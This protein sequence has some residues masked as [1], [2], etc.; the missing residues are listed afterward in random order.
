MKNKTMDLFESSDPHTG[1][2]GDPWQREPWNPG[3]ARVWP[4]DL[5][6]GD[7]V[8][9]EE[10]ERNYSGLTGKSKYYRCVVKEHSTVSGKMKTINSEPDDEFP[11]VPP[12]QLG[13]IY[14]NVGYGHVFWKRRGEK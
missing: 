9:V 3:G 4:Y 1:L 7:V 12:W 8:I 6:V 10:Y 14:L 11:A 2:H 5:Q 13:W